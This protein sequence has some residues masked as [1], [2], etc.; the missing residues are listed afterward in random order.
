MNSLL[1]HPDISREIDEVALD[2]FF[3]LGYVPSPHSIF[4]SVRQLPPGCFLT[5]EDGNI[6]VERYW[7]LEPKRSSIRSEDEAAEELLALIKDAIRIRLYS[8]VPFG[9]LLSGGVDSSLVVGLMSQLMNRPV[10]TFTVGFS[11]SDLD[12]S[13]YAAEVA[14]LFGTEHHQMIA[15]PHSAIELVQKLTAHFGEPFADASAIPTYLVSEMARQN[16]TMALSG[17][18]GDEV[19]GGYRSYRYHAMRLATEDC[20]ARYAL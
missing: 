6:E 9:A 16:V 17:D 15:R 13:Q 2:N 14:E 19:F 7:R 20:R 10:Q 5:W 8:D 11:E 18:G 1:E 12:E 4:R 3:A